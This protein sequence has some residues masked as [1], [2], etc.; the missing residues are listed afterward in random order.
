MTRLFRMMP[1]SCVVTDRKQRNDQTVDPA[2]GP[3]EHHDTVKV[4]VDEHN[5]VTLL[6]SFFLP[7]LA[8]SAILLSC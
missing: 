3:P 4:D 1:S 5:N 7:C 8:A 2:R 6:L